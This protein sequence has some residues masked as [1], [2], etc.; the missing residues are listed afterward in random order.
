[1]DPP[2]C[3]NTISIN[4]KSGRSVLGY[5]NVN[6]HRETTATSSESESIMSEFYKYE[7][8]VDKKNLNNVL[9]YIQSHKWHPFLRLWPSLVNLESFTLDDYHSIPDTLI[10]LRKLCAAN[11]LNRVYKHYLV[12]FV[13]IFCCVCFF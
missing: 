3:S 10:K 1:M 8:N 12:S 2:S 6:F 7:P 9:M 4:K 11:G 13:Y 5:N